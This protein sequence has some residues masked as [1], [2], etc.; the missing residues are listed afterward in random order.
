MY[1]PHCASLSDRAMWIWILQA[2][3]LLVL[4]CPLFRMNRELSKKLSQSK[5]SVGAT[6]Y[7][8]SESQ[9]NSTL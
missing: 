4:V 8:I 1:M 6:I 2:Q 5:K 3:V 7:M 9:Y